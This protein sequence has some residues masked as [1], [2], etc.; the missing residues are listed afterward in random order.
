ERAT[1]IG[2]FVQNHI[3]QLIALVAMEP[4]ANFDEESIRNERQKVFKSIQPFDEKKIDDLIVLGQYDKGEVNG[5]KALSYVDEKN[6][7]K[8][9][10]T[11][12]YIA[13]KFFID[14]W[15]WANVPIYI[16]TG[17]RLKARCTEIAI[18]FKFPPLKLLGHKCKNL[19]ANTIV[20]S[21]FPKQK[22]S[23]NF[24]VK[25]PG[26]ENIPYPVDMVFDY[27]D[28]FQVDSPLAYERVLIDAMKSDLS[29]F[30]R[31]DGIETMWEIVDPIS[32]ILKQKTPYK[33]EA[34]SLGPKEA[35]SLIQQDNRA[36]RLF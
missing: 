19:D 10:K 34:G 5:K 2:D 14:N 6:V 18:Q 15:R 25:F 17:K 29:L 1:V 9:S 24:N 27:K 11:P 7:A 28:V 3:L 30:A 4:P 12:T 8:D 31:Q 21:I 22:V 13:A 36:W 16:R 26:M 23:L 20:F 35:D 32:N 33:Y